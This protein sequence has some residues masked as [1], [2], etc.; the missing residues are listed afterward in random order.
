MCSEFW[1]Q[2]KEV[3]D[4]DELQLLRRRRSFYL[5]LAKLVHGIT[6]DFTVGVTGEVTGTG[7]VC[8]GI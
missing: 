2:I 3:V 4:V 6:V 7:H 1:R 5:L 8:A